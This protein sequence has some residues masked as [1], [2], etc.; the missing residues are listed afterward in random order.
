MDN[1]LSMTL[2]I[3]DNN[4][5][6]NDPWLLSWLYIDKNIIIRIFF[7]KV[8]QYLWMSC[9]NS[10]STANRIESICAAVETKVKVTLVCER[11]N[12]ILTSELRCQN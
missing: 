7:F 1:E 4:G 8:S 10:D 3:M 6:N 2:D 11:V 9:G 12:C 5:H